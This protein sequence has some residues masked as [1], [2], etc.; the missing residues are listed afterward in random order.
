MSLNDSL[1]NEID[2]SSLNK[3]EKPWAEIGLDGGELFTGV[4]DAPISEDWS[5]ILR[6]FGLDPNIFMVVDDKV[7]MSK[8][9]QSKRTESGDRDIVWLYS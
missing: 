7:K 1:N 6:S 4:L 3:Q 2:D 9:Q 5:P 8:W